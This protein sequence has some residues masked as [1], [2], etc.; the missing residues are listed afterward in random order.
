M[1]KSNTGLLLL[2]SAMDLLDQNLKTIRFLLP[3]VDG[4]MNYAKTWQKNT[5]RNYCGKD[6]PKN[7]RRFVKPIPY[8]T[9]C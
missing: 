8:G 1:C 4:P 6:K 7:D 5:N 2:M 3:D 9:K